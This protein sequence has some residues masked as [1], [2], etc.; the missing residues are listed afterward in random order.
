MK[1]MHS[2]SAIGFALQSLTMIRHRF[3][4]LPQKKADRLLKLWTT[5]LGSPCPLLPLLPHRPAHLKSPKIARRNSISD[6]SKFAIRIFHDNLGTLNVTLMHPTRLS[7]H[8]HRDLQ[9]TLSAQACPSQVIISKTDA[10]LTTSRFQRIWAVEVGTGLLVLI[11][12][13]RRIRVHSPVCSGNTGRRFRTRMV[14]VNCSRLRS[15]TLLLDMT[16][17][18]STFTAIPILG[19]SI[20]FRREARTPTAL[21]FLTW[22]PAPV[23]LI[24][25][26]HLW[27]K[28]MVSQGTTTCLEASRVV[29]RSCAF[30]FPLFLGRFNPFPYVTFVVVHCG[31]F[32]RVV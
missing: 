17:I 24:I 15:T 19:S 28:L 1:T 7:S 23:L 31:S 21:P 13:F 18:R 29:S 16:A 14:R 12:I 9:I 2:A 30:F 26:M 20:L 27:E 5:G 22:T 6:S 25:L 10:G 3:C 8:R 4:S 32:G 11:L